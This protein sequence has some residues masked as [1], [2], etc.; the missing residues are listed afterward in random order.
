MN[1]C[2]NDS[3]VTHFFF[4]FFTCSPAVTTVEHAILFRSAF[5]RHSHC[6]RSRKTTT[7]RKRRRAVRRVERISALLAGL[8]FASS[9]ASFGFPEVHLRSK[10]QMAKI[11]TAVTLSDRKPA[12]LR[13]VSY[14]LVHARQTFLRPSDKVHQYNLLIFARQCRVNGTPS[15]SVL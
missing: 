13:F 3:V 4:L 7:Y 8:P 11:A 5:P 2:E 6:E 1:S 9:N 14:L 15:Q 10:L 12:Y